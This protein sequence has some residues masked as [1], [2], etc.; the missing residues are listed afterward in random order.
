MTKPGVSVIVPTFRS[1]PAVHRTL[2]AVIRDCRSSGSAW[3]VIV[4]DNDSGTEFV[5]RLDGYRAGV[6][7]LTVIARTGLDGLNFQPGA[8]RN[9]GIEA[10]RHD[11]LI[12]LDADC[13]PGP[14]LIRAYRDR[15]QDDD[16]TIYIGHRHFVDTN[17]L[18]ADMVAADRGL[19]AKLPPVPSTSNYGQPVERRMPELE[20]LDAH[21]KPFDCMYACNMAAHR[22]CIGSHRFDPVF[23]GCWGYE[24]IE[25]G[26]RLHRAGRRFE[27]LPAAYVYHQEGASLLPEQRATGRQRN[28]AIAAGL[29]DDFAEYRSSIRRVGAVPRSV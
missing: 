5:R 21:E 27:Y 4:V 3:E 18:D 28:F 8:A 29:I 12:F 19:L 14:G 2:A 13:I 25:L 6:D 11:C 26:Y 22:R 15:I 9:A 17:G 1:W 7:G 10:A 23:D 24:D 16:R 20:Q